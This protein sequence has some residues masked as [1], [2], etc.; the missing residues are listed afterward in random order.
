MTARE[1][2]MFAAIIATLVGFCLG[3]WALI[4]WGLE[5]AIR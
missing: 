5:A 4:G 3:I 2:L 1:H